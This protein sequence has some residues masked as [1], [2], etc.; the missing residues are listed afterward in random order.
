MLNGGERELIADLGVHQNEIGVLELR[1][2]IQQDEKCFGAEVILTLLCFQVF[3]GEIAGDFRAGHG[4][5][6]LFQGVNC[7]ARFQFDGLQS[8]A[9]RI[10][11]ALLTYFTATQLRFGRAVTNGK[12]ERKCGAV[13]WKLECGNLAQRVAEST[14]NDDQ[15]DCHRGRSS[16]NFPSSLETAAFDCARGGC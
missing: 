5:F 2:R 4:K 13:C 1:L 12:T 14:G 6:R 10:K 3:L 8:A 15:F 9:L 16:N 11:I 7:V